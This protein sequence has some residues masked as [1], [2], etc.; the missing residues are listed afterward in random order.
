MYEGISVLKA[1]AVGSE[2]VHVLYQVSN[3]DCG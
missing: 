1:L 2:L 3:E